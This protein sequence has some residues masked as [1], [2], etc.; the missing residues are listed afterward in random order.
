LQKHFPKIA[1]KEIFK[2]ATL[3]GAK[4]LGIEHQFGS[5]EK[6]MQP[7]VVLINNEKAQRIN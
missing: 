6:G 4:A 5:F 7:G 2:W 3:N 1:L